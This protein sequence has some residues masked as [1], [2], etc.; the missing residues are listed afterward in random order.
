MY[1]DS[2]I[3]YRY[4]VLNLIGYNIPIYENR[5]AYIEYVCFDQIPDVVRQF[6]NKETGNCQIAPYLLTCHHGTW[7]RHNWLS[8]TSKSVTSLRSVELLMKNMLISLR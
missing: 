2:G 4:I 7:L 8:C 6:K 1:H 5:I 3:L